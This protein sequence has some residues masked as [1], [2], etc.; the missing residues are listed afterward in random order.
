MLVLF[1]IGIQ[2]GNNKKLQAWGGDIY[3]PDKAISLEMATGS[4]DGPRAH[5]AAWQVD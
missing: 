1:I 4:P 2:I 5:Q 3:K